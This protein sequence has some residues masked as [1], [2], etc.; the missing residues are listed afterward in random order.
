MK[1]LLAGCLLAVGIGASVSV[2]PAGATE[3]VYVC[4][5]GVSGVATTVTS[6][7]FAQNVRASYFEQGQGRYIQAYSPV[8]GDMYDMSCVP[9]MSI[10]LNSW[11]W[12]AV[13]ARC[14]GGSD[15]VVWIW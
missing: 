7:Q 13:A 4:P 9:G 11:P 15:A 3:P 2:P 12:E 8:T 1:K 14:A 10:T 6:C 5:G